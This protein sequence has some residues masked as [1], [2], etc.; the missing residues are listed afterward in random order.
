MVFPRDYADMGINIEVQKQFMQRALID[1]A[2]M[3][4]GSLF[5]FGHHP[6]Q[7]GRADDPAGAQRRGDDFGERTGVND[8]GVLAR[9]A[10]DSC[11]RRR[12]SSG[13]LVELDFTVRI[14][15]QNKHVIAPA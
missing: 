4:I 9:A 15:F 6:D 8:I 3:Q 12:I 1:G 14:V 2:G 10:V 11:H 7:F 5:G 13:G